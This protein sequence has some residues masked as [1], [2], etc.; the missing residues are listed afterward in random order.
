M[1]VGLVPELANDTNARLHAGLGRFRPELAESEPQMT[2]FAQP[3]PRSSQN[4]PTYG[5]KSLDV[6]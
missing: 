1:L 5:D 6:G 3:W 2:K 4:W